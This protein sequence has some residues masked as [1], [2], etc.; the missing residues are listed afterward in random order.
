M[1]EQ[2]QKFC[3]KRENQRVVF[4][5]G[6][7]DI[8]HAG[9]VQY[10]QAARALGDLLVVGLNSDA[11]VRRLKG[12][13]RPIN[14]QEDRAL[15]LAALSS[16]DYVFIFEEDTPYKLIQKIKPDILV[17]GGDWQIS[18]IVGSDL[19]LA[20]GGE[21]KSLLFVPGKSSSSIIEKILDQE[22]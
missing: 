10:L 3:Q 14:S 20:R 18:E 22:K 6:C 11:S 13:S 2:Y 17:K 9:H 7:F 1:S 12:S 15:V 8:L 5:N 16:V 4:T 21:V 19:V